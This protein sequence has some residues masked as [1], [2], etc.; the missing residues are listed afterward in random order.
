MSPAVDHFNTDFSSMCKKIPRHTGELARQMANRLLPFTTFMV[1]LS[2]GLLRA[3]C[4][5][6]HL[7][8]CRIEKF[9][10]LKLCQEEGLTNLFQNCT[11]EVVWILF[12][13]GDGLKY[14]GPKRAKL[15]PK[16]ILFVNTSKPK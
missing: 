12:S 10:F 4:C 6:G 1:C 15:D 7:Y 9:D 3:A 8:L 2:M 11:F 16:I 13:C 5:N 14:F